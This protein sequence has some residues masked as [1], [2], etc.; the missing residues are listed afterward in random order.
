M[1]ST[2]ASAALREACERPAATIASPGPS[3]AVLQS[4]KDPARASHAK[5]MRESRAELRSVPERDYV[6]AIDRWLD[7]GPWEGTNWFFT[8]GRGLSI[9]LMKDGN[10]LAQDGVPIV[11][12]DPIR[13]RDLPTGTR[14]SRR[15]EARALAAVAVRG[16]AGWYDGQRRKLRD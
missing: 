10:D 15:L 11:S 13:L 12:R 5:R 2:A 9:R 4:Q 6:Q 7:G 14:T 3:A 1:I 8:G 16:D